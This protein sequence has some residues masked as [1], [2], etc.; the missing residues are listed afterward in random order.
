MKGGSDTG[1]TAAGA[2]T[3]SPAELPGWDI[4]THLRGETRR[5]M[6]ILNDVINSLPHR[7]TKVREIHVCAHWTA[8]LSKRCGL[9]STF[10][11][12]GH[13]HKGVRDVGHLTKKNASELALYSR[14]E[15]LLEASIGMAAINS[16]ID[17]DE[18]TCI[19]ANAYEILL[20]KGRGKNVAVVGHFPFLSMLKDSVKNLWIIEKRPLE[21][22]LREDV[23]EEILPQCDVVG[24][25][26]TTFINHT[27]EGL[28]AH[29]KESFVAMIG[30]T[31][32]LTP[33][34]FD[35]GIDVISGS[36]VVDHHE[37][38]RF[39][40]QGATFKELHRHGVKLLTMMR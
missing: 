4:E 17:I 8:V 7:G 25:T 36:K 12:E 9:A 3:K 34:L 20:E 6:K 1:Y 14:S 2:F 22:D 26:G 30:P 18:S 15:H 11:E 19:E 38:I 33:V 29:C 13:P 21:G 37:V 5:V 24:I 23:A 39:I 32:P 40:S 10:K 16:L 27:L 31:T 28:L 35:Y